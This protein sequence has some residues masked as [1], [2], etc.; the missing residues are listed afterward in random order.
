[1]LDAGS[2]ADAATAELAIGEC[3]DTVLHTTTAETN[4]RIP[5]AKVFET[6]RVRLSFLCFFPMTCVFRP[7]ENSMTCNSRDISYVLNQIQTL[8]FLYGMKLDEWRPGS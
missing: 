4:I 5:A 2:G 6:F 7:T 3:V 8:C 1:M